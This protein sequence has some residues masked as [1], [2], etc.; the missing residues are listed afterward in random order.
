VIQETPKEVLLLNSKASY[1]SLASS[2]GNRTGEIANV[3]QPLLFEETLGDVKKRMRKR[4]RSPGQF[5][6]LFG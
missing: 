1:A 6:P 5:V 4:K 3:E 2:E